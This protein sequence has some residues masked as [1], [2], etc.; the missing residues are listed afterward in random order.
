MN[1]LITISSQL[2]HSLELGLYSPL[3]FACLK[4]LIPLLYEYSLI[5][6]TMERDSPD[7]RYFLLVFFLLGLPL[8]PSILHAFVL[9][10]TISNVWSNM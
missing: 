2:F 8:V 6:S 4:A 9:S 3:S 1:L 5:A 10:E 7:K